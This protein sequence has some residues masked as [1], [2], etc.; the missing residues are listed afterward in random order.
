M[1][2]DE[3]A[4]P[5]AQA[6]SASPVHGPEAFAAMRRR[7]ASTAE[8]STCW[9]THVA[10]GCTTDELDKLVFEFAMD[11]GAFPATLH[12]RGYTQ[13]DLHLDQ[14]RRLPRHPE[15]QAAARGRH[16]Q[17][18][19]DA[20]RSTAGT[21]IR[22]ACISSA[23]SR[24]GRERLCEVTY[25]AMMRGIARDRPGATTNDIGAAIQSSWKASAARVVRDFCGHGLGRVFHDAPND[26]ALRAS[27]ATTSS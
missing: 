23:R 24:G 2:E 13:I 17:H 27:R 14:S 21:A 5:R 25:E 10:P 6:R 22:A 19:R 9:R 18:R 11:H 7:A 1:I 16:R 20:D 8:A 12:Y 4:T 3:I 26:P 15:R